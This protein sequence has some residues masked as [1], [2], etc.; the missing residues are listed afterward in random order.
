MNS[1]MQQSQ[2]FLTRVPTLVSSSSPASQPQPIQQDST[3]QFDQQQRAPSPLPAPLPRTPTIFDS[4]APLTRT[5]TL[6]HAHHSGLPYSTE[7]PTSTAASPTL[8]PKP[9]PTPAPQSQPT[10]APPAPP[11]PLS[12]PGLDLLRP[13]TYISQH[14]YARAHPSGSRPTTPSP[15]RQGESA[16]ATGEKPLPDVPRQ[17]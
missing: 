8:Q 6:P 16:S 5:P 1:A 10:L 14:T 13:K 3:Q 7:K 17:A 11:M 15:L 2:P 4:P 9:A 12:T